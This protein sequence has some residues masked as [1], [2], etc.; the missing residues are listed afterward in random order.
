LGV[1]FGSGGYQ[2]Q[3]AAEF[4]AKQALQRFLEDL[5]REEKRK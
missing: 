1:K 4:A 3:T 5:V 2:S